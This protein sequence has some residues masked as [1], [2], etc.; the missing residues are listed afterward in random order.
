[1]IT[2][3]EIEQTAKIDP[4]VIAL[5]LEAKGWKRS[6]GPPDWGVDY[7]NRRDFRAPL[8]M[9]F[10]LPNE[11]AVAL[12]GQMVQ[13]LSE[14]ENRSPQAIL[15]D[16]LAT[17]YSR[18]RC[19]LHPRVTGSQ[20]APL[21]A[22]SE[23]LVAFRQRLRHAALQVER[24]GLAESFVATS[25]LH[26]LKLLPQETNEFDLMIGSK[27]PAAPHVWSAFLDLLGRPATA[28][29]PRREL[30][31]GET[32][33]VIDPLRQAMKEAGITDLSGQ[34]LQAGEP[35]VPGAGLLFRLSA[36]GGILTGGDD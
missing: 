36:E 20:G 32:H 23:M 8:E 11:R 5:Y 22:L 3:Q 12:Q 19:T 34:Y 1:M 15:W 10:V 9:Y 18:V 24:T 6:K 7:W 29:T 33:Y 26:T 17:P 28:I 2:R 4:A 27:D 14:Y 13:Y 35:N 25:Y 16:W 30:E 31:P 21:D